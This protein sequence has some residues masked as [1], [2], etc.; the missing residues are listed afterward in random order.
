MLKL[1]N[2]CIVVLKDEEEKSTNYRVPKEL[3]LEFQKE[4][5]QYRS[6]SAKPKAIRCV[7]TGEVFRCA[8]A[9]YKWLEEKGLQVSYS[10]E[11][12]IKKACYNPNRT[13]YGF[14]WEFVE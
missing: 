12:S 14:H 13:A 5:A 2:R 7:E 9:T 6:E 8:R 11:A 3:F 10:F 4:L 1:K